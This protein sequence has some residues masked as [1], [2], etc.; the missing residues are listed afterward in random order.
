MFL[1]GQRIEAYRLMILSSNLAT[2]NLSM[3]RW[4]SW[5]C[6][7]LRGATL[8]RLQNSRRT[9]VELF[10]LAYSNTIHLACSWLKGDN[11]DVVLCE[12]D[13]EW[14]FS[15]KLW[16]PHYFHSTFAINESSE[17]SNCILD[18]ILKFCDFTTWKFFSE[19]LKKLNISKTPC[20]TSSVSKIEAKGSYLF[21]VHSINTYKDRI[22]S[23]FIVLYWAVLLT[24]IRVTTK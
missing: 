16:Y 15:T 23:N 21:E 8:E 17:L 13:W 24:H 9:I 11:L 4:I 3:M 2:W 22:S 18:T 7:T 5:T 14:Q 6:G 10:S 20:S 12:Q 19:T 1:A